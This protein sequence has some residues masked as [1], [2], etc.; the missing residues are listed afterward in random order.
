MVALAPV[1]RT[2]SATVLKSGKPSLTVPPLPGA[3]PPTDLRAV[4]AAL[5][6]VESAGLAE[7]LAENACRFI[8]EDTHITKEG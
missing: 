7:A 5:L 8:N 3:T 1:L 6:S 4:I 2:A